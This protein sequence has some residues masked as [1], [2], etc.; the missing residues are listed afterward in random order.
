VGGV[1]D[2]ASEHVVLDTRTLSILASACA[3]ADPNAD[4]EARDRGAIS[5]CGCSTSD[6]NDALIGQGT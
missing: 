2:D 1:L 6:S 3:Q 4:L 5:M